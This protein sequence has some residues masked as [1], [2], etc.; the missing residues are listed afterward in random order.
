MTREAAVTKTRLPADQRRALVLNAAAKLFAERGY[1]G[2]T[3]DQVASASGVTKP[4]L[5]RHFASKQQLYMALLIRHSD[6]MPSFVDFIP[7]DGGGEV[8]LRAILD[9]W[10]RYAQENGHGW[11][12]LFRD[13]GG[14]AEIV[15]YR[16]QVGIRATEVVAGFLR[17]ADVALKPSMLVPTAEMIRAGL[18]GLVVWWADRPEVPRETI[19]AAAVHLLQPV[20]APRE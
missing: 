7:R 20:L 12:M 6:D 9:P 16:R 19:V 8:D 5:Y 13:A 18:A 3:L 14:D 17:R 15:E 2:T 11:Q 10:F 1:D 4:I